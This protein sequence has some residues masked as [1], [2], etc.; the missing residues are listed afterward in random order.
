MDFSLERR[1]GVALIKVLAQKI[2][3]AN[4]A[5]FRT[6]ILPHV[7]GQKSVVLD[8]AEVTFIDSSGLGAILSVLR[9]L[10]ADSGNLRLCNMTRNV[11]MLFEL[12]RMHRV[13]DIF[14]TPEEAVASFGS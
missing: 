13:F 7:Q 3:A 14:V 11:R 6:G 9:S 4:A 8:L 12:V 5:D 10:T 2:D 1:S